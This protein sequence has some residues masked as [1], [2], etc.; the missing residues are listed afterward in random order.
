MPRRSRLTLSLIAAVA[1]LGFAAATPASALIITSTWEGSIAAF[2][3]TGVFGTPFASVDA[4]FRAV[5]T[6]DT[7][8][9]GA[10]ETLSPGQRSF[11][12][13]ENAA[14]P[15]TAVLTIL[16]RS[17][18]IGAQ[19]DYTFGSIYRQDA[20]PFGAVHDNVDNV[21]RH[22]IDGPIFEQVVLS[23]NLGSRTNDFTGWDYRTPMTYVFDPPNDRQGG[24]FSLDRFNVATGV[25]LD[26]L[27]GR[28]FAT[29]VTVTVGDAAVVPEPASWALMIA[30]FGAAGA[31]LRRRRAGAFP[32]PA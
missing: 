12:T 9:L 21:A 30:G 14:N 29:S 7:E 6:T 19:G 4:P 1:A 24:A 3:I 10:I 25:Q 13:G 17:F 22:R 2:D 32:V 18:V 27:F 11:L 16:G 28:V 8:T 26:S 15:T 31:V 23:M 5:F 20:F